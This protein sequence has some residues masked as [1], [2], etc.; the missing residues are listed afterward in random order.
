MKSMAKAL[1]LPQISQ[2]KKTPRDMSN[3]CV[4]NGNASSKYVV[5]DGG[6]VAIMTFVD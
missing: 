1:E 2:C 5:R 6:Q 3:V 4:M